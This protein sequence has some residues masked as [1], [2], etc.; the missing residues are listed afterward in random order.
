M[1]CTRCFRRPR[2]PHDELC[3][4]CRFDLERLDAAAAAVDNST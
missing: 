4:G 3:L 2:L 1:T